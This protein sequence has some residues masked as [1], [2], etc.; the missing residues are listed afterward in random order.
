MNSLYRHK[1]SAL[2]MCKAQNQIHKGSYHKRKYLQTRKKQCTCED[3]PRTRDVRERALTRLHLFS[4]VLQ[5]TYG[6]G[7]LTSGLSF[8]ARSGG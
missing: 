7:I 4:S 5:S 6:R 8:L 3:F 2:F 1:T